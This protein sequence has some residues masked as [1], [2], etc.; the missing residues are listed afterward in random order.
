MRTDEAIL[1]LSRIGLPTV[2]PQLIEHEDY[3]DATNLLHA[4]YMTF[5]GHFDKDI[6][7]E[8]SPLLNELQD[9][10]EGL[11]NDRR[12]LLYS[13]VC[14][15]LFPYHS[16]F[17]APL[18]D[19]DKPY[20]GRG[21]TDEQWRTLYAHP[22]LDSLRQNFVNLD[23][24]KALDIIKTAWTRGDKGGF[25][26]LLDSL[27]VFQNRQQR[28]SEELKGHSH[29]VEDVATLPGV[30]VIVLTIPRGTED[31]F[32]ASLPPVRIIISNAD[33]PVDYT[34]KIEETDPSVW[35]AKQQD[36]W[37]STADHTFESLRTYLTTSLK[38]RSE[39]IGYG[40]YYF[41]TNN[42]LNVA[43]AANM[44][45][46]IH[47]YLSI[48][49][50]FAANAHSRLM[51]QLN[52]VSNAVLGPVYT[53]RYLRA[54]KDAPWVTALNHANGLLRSDGGINPLA[55]A[56]ELC[57]YGLTQGYAFLNTRLKS[58]DDES[59]FHTGLSDA[60]KTLVGEMIALSSEG[61]QQ[62]AALERYEKKY[63]L[64]PDTALFP[65]EERSRLAFK[66]L[67]DIVVGNLT[68]AT[69]ACAIADQ[70][71]GIV[72]NVPFQ[73]I[74]D[75]MLKAG[76][77]KNV[78]RLLENHS[79]HKSETV[80]TAI[81]EPLNALGYFVFETMSVKD[82][83]EVKFRAVADKDGTIFIRNSKKPKYRSI[84]EI[85]RDGDLVDGKLMQMFLGSITTQPEFEDAI[86][87]QQAAVETFVARQTIVTEIEM[88]TSRLPKED[89]S[90]YLGTLQAQLPV[91][92]AK[93][94]ESGIANADTIVQDAIREVQN[95]NRKP[96]FKRVIQA[97]SDVSGL[98]K[99]K[100]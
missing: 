54:G 53:H 59:L 74:A 25:L 42:D 7:A 56:N 45:A 49:S 38:N 68:S 19:V 4:R 39:S 13:V 87:E 48:P 6:V 47:H 63:G 60:V 51:Q 15:D 40:P 10:S 96:L 98:M 24:S 85:A 1:Q 81:Q 58:D 71:P 20:P 72:D 95:Q 46:S 22:F 80:L 23:R 65:V 86:A 27:T 77:L 83:A 94:S 29:F 3:V 37:I 28:D 2:L 32:T 21:G 89:Q 50:N 90:Y 70:E 64:H 18:R 62:A 5:A 73:I 99:P 43:T 78:M 67:S 31:S 26:F 35:A 97:L 33:L 75:T 92:A 34:D 36:F 61:D 8:W 57:L 69:T 30:E 93:L 16:A 84:E 55:A 17:L 76:D 100:V 9:A 82:D 88:R 14:Q 66:D 44:M 12:N 11:S 41:A 79:I 91:M 52:N